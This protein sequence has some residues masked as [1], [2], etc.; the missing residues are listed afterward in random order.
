MSDSKITVLE[1]DYKKTE[2]RIINFIKKIVE[3]AKAQG[4]I[5]GLSGGV[6]SSLAA[7]I[8]VRALGKERVLGVLM[9]VS[10]TPQEDM[11]D[12]KELA[13]WLGIKTEAIPLESIYNAFS[14]S[15]KHDQRGTENEIPMANV[16][17]RIRMVILYYYANLNNYLVVGTG[18]RSEFLIGFFTKYGDGG[19][20]FY[21]ISQLYKS[22]V[23]KLAE[24]L[25]VPR[26][27]AYKPSSPRLYPGHKATDEIP[28]DYE[29]LDPVLIGLF[30]K[31]FSHRQ[32]SKL[33][34]VPIEIVEEIQKRFNKSKHKRTYP[35]M[36][37]K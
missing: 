14:K 12:A 25:G 28:L 7:T 29:Q 4:V 19:A 18:D 23:R 37:Q 8:C 10:F 3:E 27:M 32:V 5:L 36:P 24:H 33:T 15:L 30:D 31:K 21:P 26:K 1:L 9:P 13:K 20:D 6:D 2:N 17:A 16:L 34:G 22:Q 11:K 35:L